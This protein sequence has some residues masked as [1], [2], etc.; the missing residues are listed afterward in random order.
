[1]WSLAV[2][3]VT[4][5]RSV[6]SVPIFPIPFDSLL[7]QFHHHQSLTPLLSFESVKWQSSGARIKISGRGGFLPGTTD[8][9]CLTKHLLAT[10][11]T[12]RA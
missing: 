12:C 3:E 6:R 5:W 1:M 10:E 9:Y 2:K 8:R 4:S 7:T 11:I